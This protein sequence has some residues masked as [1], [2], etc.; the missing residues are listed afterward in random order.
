M[1]VSPDNEALRQVPTRREFWLSICVAALLA[2]GCGGNSNALTVFAASSMTEFLEELLIVEG[3]PEGS[4]MPLINTAG[5]GTLL[6]QIDEG[7]N[8]DLVILAGASH[9][10]QLMAGNDFLPATPFAMT[11]LSIILSPDLMHSGLSFGDLWS[12]DLQGAMCVSSAPCGQLAARFGSAKGVN[13]EGLSRE[14]NVRAVLTKVEHGD[15][16]FGFV[17]ETDFLSSEAEITEVPGAGAQG[18]STTYY[19]AVSKEAKDIAELRTMVNRITGE[20]GREVLL[21]LGFMTP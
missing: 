15:V 11:H 3:P 21:K 19:L 1:T 14:P 13:M 5:S 12:G 18:F 9:M 4:K 10:E 6:L 8:A 17:Y 20:A 7:A 16:D 2:F